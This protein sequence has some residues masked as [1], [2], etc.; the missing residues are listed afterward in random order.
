MA[1]PAAGRDVPN[2]PPRD[3]SERLEPNHPEPA[4]QEAQ[5]WI[6]VSGVTVQ[7]GSGACCNHTEMG[8][9]VTYYDRGYKYIALRHRC[10]V[11]CCGDDAVSGYRVGQRLCC[12][13]G[14]PYMSKVFTHVWL[15][16]KCDAHANRVGTF[17]HQPSKKINDNTPAK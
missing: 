4:C 2:A 9:T 16:L 7:R 10:I 13:C 17:K 11:T 5:K 6:E 12:V 15:L 14:Q 1:S 3:D 8:H